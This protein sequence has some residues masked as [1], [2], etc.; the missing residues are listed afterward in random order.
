MEAGSDTR[1]PRVALA[2]IAIGLVATVAAALLSTDKPI[3]AAELGW[4]ARA[5][6]P[7]SRPA[8]IPGNG[9]IR[10]TEAG[11][12]A[13]DANIS[14]Y[15]L[16]RVAAVLVVSPGSSVSHGQVQCAVRVPG[17]RAIVARTPENRASYPLPSSEEDLENQPVPRTV[18]VEFNSHS[19]D[20][21]RVEL[22]DAFE[23][24]ASQTGVSSTGRRSNSAS[25]S[26]NGPSPA[27]S[28]INP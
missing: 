4:E 10:L 23:A 24:F 6:M 26:G 8:A 1:P 9:K 17:I 27:P 25:R 21:A 12:R 13:T 11:I 18:T 7:D 19:S 2:V 28:R 16:F 5:A 15:R 14:G 20:L 22:G 3:G